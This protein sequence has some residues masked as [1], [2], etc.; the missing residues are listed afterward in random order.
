MHTVHCTPN[1]IHFKQCN[2]NCIQKIIMKNKPQ[3]NVLLCFIQS[4]VLPF[5]RLLLLLFS[6]SHIIHCVM[7]RVH[8]LFHLPPSTFLSFQMLKSFSFYWFRFIIIIECENAN[9]SPK[10]TWTVSP[11]LLVHQDESNS[12]DHLQWI[13]QWTTLSYA[14]RHPFD[15]III[16]S[17]K[18]S[19]SVAQLWAWRRF[20]QRETVQIEAKIRDK[21]SM[22]RTKSA[23]LH[24]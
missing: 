2:G 3:G 8:T 15:Q 14:N 12:F 18:V 20:T 6:E 1:T 17:V 13:I 11:Q 10:V 16:I 9:N 19:K 24:K 4:S 7:C 21:A 23:Q 22:H 5:V